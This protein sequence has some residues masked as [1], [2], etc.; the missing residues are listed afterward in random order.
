MDTLVSVPSS[1][2]S[3]TVATST[4]VTSPHQQY[5]LCTPSPPPGRTRHVANNFSVDSSAYHRY[6]LDRRKSFRN[7]GSLGPTVASAPSVEQEDYRTPRPSVIAIKNGKSFDFGGYQSSACSDTN[8]LIKVSENCTYHG[9]I[10]RSFGDSLYL[11]FSYSTL[12]FSKIV[13]GRFP[14]LL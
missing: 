5:S 1:S 4:S 9:E 7:R 2:H 3:T 12:K 14:D 13:C 11:R 10:D 8:G 6:L